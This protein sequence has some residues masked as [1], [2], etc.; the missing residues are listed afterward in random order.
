[1]D[2]LQ[3]PNKPF[4]F[5]CPI[6]KAQQ[7]T[8]LVK[9]LG[10]LHHLQFALLTALF[11]WLAW[12]VLGPKGL[13]AYFVI[14]CGFE[15]QFRLRKRSEF[16]CRSCGFDPFLYKNDSKKSREEV[17]RRLQERILAEGH[18]RGKK[19]KNYQT[20]SDEKAPDVERQ[21]EGEAPQA[22]PEL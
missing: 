13:S 2:S 5:Y 14:W 7:R 16:I 17:R 15:F 19:L 9:R 1:M 8:R 11:V 21:P 18:F 4:H 6:C 10:A 12:P 3:K 20:Q 22:S